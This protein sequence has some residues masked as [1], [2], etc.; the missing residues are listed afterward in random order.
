MAGRV[1]LVKLIEESERRVSSFI[2]DT[3]NRIA[4]IQ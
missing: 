4:N 1:H 3:S 2:P